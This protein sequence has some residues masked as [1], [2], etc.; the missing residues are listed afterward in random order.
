VFNNTFDFGAASLDHSA[1]VS[2]I[3]RLAST[4][5]L[6][7]AYDGVGFLMS[8]LSQGVELY[9][10]RSSLEN[11]GGHYVT[12]LGVDSGDTITK[13]YFN[14]SFVSRVQDTESLN[15]TSILDV[16]IATIDTNILMYA[17]QGTEGSAAAIASRADQADMTGVT[18]L[19]SDLTV[20]ELAL[21][22]D[23]SPLAPANLTESIDVTLRANV[24][25]TANLTNF[26][27]LFA[28]NVDQ[29][30][31]TID[32]PLA[33]TNHTCD[34]AVNGDGGKYI[35][36]FVCP[37]VAPVCLRW[38]SEARNFSDA[39]CR[40]LSGYTENEV[41]CECIYQ[42]T[43]TIF[44]LSG[45]LTEVKT[46]V[47]QTSEPTLS[48]SLQPT[49]VPSHTPTLRPTPLPTASPSVSQ[50]PTHRPTLMPSPIPS[51]V[52]SVSS[53]PTPLTWTPSSA[54]T[55]TPT[56]GTPM[57]TSPFPTPTPSMAPTPEDTI[58]VS[59]KFNIV[60]TK[61]PSEDKERILKETIAFGIG[62]MESEIKGFFTSVSSRRLLNDDKL[63]SGTNLTF[64]SDKKSDSAQFRELNTIV[65]WSVDF[66]VQSS[67]MDAL[68]VSEAL[69]FD[70]AEPYFTDAISSNI[71]G[72]SVDTNSLEVVVI[73]NPTPSPTPL[74]SPPP[75]PFPTQCLDKGLF[76]EAT[77]AYCNISYCES[78]PFA[79]L[80]DRTWF[81]TVVISHSYHL[82]TNYSYFT[83]LSKL[84]CFHRSIYSVFYSC[85]TLQLV[86][87]A[88]FE[89]R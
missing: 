61:A 24:Q 4:A 59:T 63:N 58:L 13:V 45:D 26:D 79:G 40:V 16:Y 21:V 37:Y 65:V 32:C 68:T 9:S 71:A 70:L 10:Y 23:P 25:F 22:D 57:P 19:R 55:P 83:V 11:L 82:T 66:M 42:P 74:P 2:K 84:A 75:T 49:S 20:V 27:K 1:N 3:L 43:S 69:A 28:C 56:R 53:E 50:L 48:P 89:Q 36:E 87:S 78:C 73:W 31:V 41:T 60:A 88:P 47:L 33:P 64:R 14:K 35:V 15:E 81:V 6:I 7:D 18:L 34:F 72:A 62:R 77:A 44:A 86:P 39:G 85:C 67:T 29:E 8:G 17:L 5:L 51:S 46:T 12:L 30:I 52:P 38:Q 80:C 76:C 54:P